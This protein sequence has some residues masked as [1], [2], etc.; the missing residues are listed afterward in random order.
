MILI[1]VLFPWLSFLLRGKIIVGILCLIL[2]FTL[3]GW[4]PAS[5]WAV[6][7]QLDARNKK[8]IKDLQWNV[9]S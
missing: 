5:I 8:R 9:R 4:L 2:Q 1:A 3:I 6:A 7:A